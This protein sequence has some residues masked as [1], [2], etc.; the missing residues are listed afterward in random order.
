MDQYGGGHTLG[1]F[2]YLYGQGGYPIYRLKLLNFVG[3]LALRGANG[4]LIL[5][6][7]RA[8][9]D[10]LKDWVWSSLQRVGRDSS[11]VNRAKFKFN[12]PWP[13]LVEQTLE[14]YASIFQV[15]LDSQL[16]GAGDGFQAMQVEGEGHEEAQN[17]YQSDR[18][19]AM[20]STTGAGSVPGRQAEANRGAQGNSQHP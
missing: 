19:T 12:L 6:T 7:I 18:D 8:N 11:L 15:R 20:R 17:Y 9:Q 3:D 1:L 5:E 13:A 10:S 14:Q 4:A 2:S 16:G